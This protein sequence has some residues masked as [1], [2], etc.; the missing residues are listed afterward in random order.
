MTDKISPE[1]CRGT[2]IDSEASDTIVTTQ[3]DPST[4]DRYTATFS[5]AFAY[6]EEHS[7]QN[8]GQS[9][10][11]SHTTIAWRACHITEKGASDIAYI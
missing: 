9:S 4:Q 11:G 6:E 5:V 10:Q 7:H 8:S 2:K 1:R 3:G